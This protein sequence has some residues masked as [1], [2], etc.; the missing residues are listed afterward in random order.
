M[1]KITNKFLAQVP[2]LTLKGNNTGSTANVTDLSVAQVQTL[3]GITAGNSWATYTPTVTGFGTVTN[4]RGSYKQVGDSLF[5]KCYFTAG[6][7]A[8]SLASVTLPGGFTLS[9]STTKI[10]ISNT[11]TQSGIVV[12]SYAGNSTSGTDF[13]TWVGAV[14][15]APASSTSL[16]YFGLSVTDRGNKLIPANGNAIADSS[17]NFSFQC[18]VILT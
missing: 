17:Q 5:I 2:A 9:T 6:T 16:V 7:V 18:E 8:A 13:G 3:L 12:G 15:T 1:S 14:T 4:L 10:P 11:N